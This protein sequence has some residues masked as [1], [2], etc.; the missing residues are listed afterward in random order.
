MKRSAVAM[1]IAGV[2]FVVLS[3]QAFAQQGSLSFTVQNDTAQWV[4]ASCWGRPVHVVQ[5]DTTRSGILCDPNF[6]RFQVTLNHQGTVYGETFSHAC[7]DVMKITVEEDVEETV[8]LPGSV[9]K[10]GEDVTVTVTHAFG[11]TDSCE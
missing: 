9:T 2:A 3:M 6:N 11:F 1:G 7:E 8:T 5:P 4:E 10:T